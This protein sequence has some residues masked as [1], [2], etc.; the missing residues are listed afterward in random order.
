MLGFQLWEVVTNSSSLIP[1][2]S[3]SLIS[4]WRALHI[5]ISCMY[6]IVKA[7]LIVQLILLFQTLIPIVRDVPNPMV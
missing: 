3:L 5:I 1:V 6:Y 7:H 4:T 2:L